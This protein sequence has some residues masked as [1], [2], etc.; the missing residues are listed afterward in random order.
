MSFEDFSIR[1]GHANLREHLWLHPGTEPASEPDDGG[2]P[3]S[4]SAFIPVA[5]RRRLAVSE[6]RAISSDWHWPSSNCISGFKID[7]TALSRMTAP[8]VWH[9]RGVESEEFRAIGDR[10]WA[11]LCNSSPISCIGPVQWLG[12]SRKQNAPLQFPQR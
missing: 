3:Y 9:H 4:E 8:E 1:V 7:N 10:L 11:Y 6:L 2:E 5:E 12:V